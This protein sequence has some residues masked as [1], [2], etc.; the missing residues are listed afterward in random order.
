VKVIDLE[1]LTPRGE[2]SAPRLSL[3]SI[4]HISQGSIKM[5]APGDFKLGAANF[6]SS[7][8][9]RLAQH[10]RFGLCN[11]DLPR[12]IFVDP[13]AVIFPL[14]VELLHLYMGRFTSLQPHNR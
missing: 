5:M 4:R 2:T 12:Q 11:I 6:K 14:G 1:S 9:S 13:K 3:W 10:F 7:K 8:T